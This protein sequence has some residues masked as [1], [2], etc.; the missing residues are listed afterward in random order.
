MEKKQED[1]LEVATT[2]LSNNNKYK[3]FGNNV[4][5]QLEDMERSQQL[6]AKKLIS[7]VLFHGQMGNLKMSSTVLLDQL[8]QQNWQPTYNYMV[9]PNQ[10]IR[11]DTHY[12]QNSSASTNIGSSAA[13]PITR[14]RDEVYQVQSAQRDV[15]QE[16]GSF[17]RLD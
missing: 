9:S 8:P 10:Q 6:L 7:E 16:L 17:L 5:F 3:A 14:E 15:R 1:F 2:V 11:Y 4:A 13:T 12:P